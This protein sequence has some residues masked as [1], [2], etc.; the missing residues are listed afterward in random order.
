MKTIVIFSGAG[1]SKESG[2]P[3]FRDSLSG[4]WEN[5]NIEQVAS[6]GGWLE[7]PKTVLDFYAARWKNVQACEPN[8]AHKA[9][10][11]LDRK[12]RVIN[13]T[14]NID[15]LLE[16]AGASHVQHLH[17]RIH[18]RKCEWHQSI[19]GIPGDQEF[20][21][22]Y[23]VDQIAP[24]QIGEKCPKC[25]GQL[26]PDVDWFGEAVDMKW[27]YYQELAQTTD[28]FIGVGT[29]GRVEPAATLLSVF[30]PAKERYFIDPDPMQGLRTYELLQGTACKHMPILAKSLIERLGED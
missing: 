21:C 15:D 12:F 16:K 19:S 4:L 28:V 25:G 1:L 26:R 30:L 11:D 3:T 5:F 2:I 29:S 10:A 14:Q 8:A 24:V 22:D 13:I 17:G 27:D 9:I 18:A 23:R 6:R 20:C 7:D